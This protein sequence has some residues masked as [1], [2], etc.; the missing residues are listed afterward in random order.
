M[1]CSVNKWGEQLTVIYSG[2]SESRGHYLPQGYLL[3]ILGPRAP[4]CQGLPTL[5]AIKKLRSVAYTWRHIAAGENADR[6]YA[7][8]MTLQGLWAPRVE[9]KF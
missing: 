6:V 9:G 3:S 7:V 2:L 5:L 4:M 8:D 1:L